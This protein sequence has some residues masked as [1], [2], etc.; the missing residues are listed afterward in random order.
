MRRT[1]GGRSGAATR[2]E[3]GLDMADTIY[4]TTLKDDFVTQYVALCEVRR[5]S[6]GEFRP[7]ALCEVRHTTTDLDANED[8]VSV[9]PFR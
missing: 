2:R 1:R 7:A 6:A 3:K 5:T 4:I 9:H 8:R